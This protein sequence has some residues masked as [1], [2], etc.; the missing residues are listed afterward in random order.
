[1]RTTPVLLSLAA[2]ATAA[3]PAQEPVASQEPDTA[4]EAQGPKRMTMEESL[5]L[6]SW[7]GYR[8]SADNAR[9]VFTKR[10]M[11]PEDW[12]SVTHV[13]VHEL[14]TGEELQLTNS[15]G[16]E[17][18]PR[19][20]PDGR[21]LFTSR[22]GEGEEATNRLWVIS[23]RGGEAQPFFDDE[24]APTGGDFTRDFGMLAYTEESDRPDKE[25]WEARTKVRDDGY[26][27]EKKLTYDHLW[28]YDAETGEKTQI[29]DDDFDDNGPRWSP[30]GRWIAFT[31]NRTG[32]RMGDPDRSD[33][34]DIFV[35][36]ADG[37]EP[38][39][40]TTNSGPDGGPVWSPDGTRIAYTGSPHQNSGAGQSDVWVVDVDGG[41]PRNLTEGLDYSASGVVW[42]ADGNQIYFSVAEGLTS[43]LYRIPSGGGAPV[44]VLPDDEFVYGGA[45]LSEDGSTLLFTGSSPLAP[46]EVFLADADGSRVRRVL[47]P[48]NGMAGF[49]LARV[50]ALT[51][52]GA[53]GWE[54][55]GVLTYPLGYEPGSRVP[56]VLSVHGGPHGRFS[57]SFNSGAQIWAARGYAVLQGNPRGS[58][59]RTWE[60]SNANV[61]DWGGKDFQDLMAGVDHVIGMGVADPDRLVV[62]GGSYGG[63]MTFWTVTQTDR[64]K[65]AIGHAAISDWYSFYGQTDIPHLLEF[66]FGGLPWVT[67]ETFERFSPI[68]YAENV[69]T[70]LL[71]THGEEDRRVPIS[72]GEQ[73]Y[74]SLKK[75]G[76][77]VEFL[78]FPRE[79]H[80]IGE[81]RH[82]IFLDAEQ[83]A[84]IE[85]F[86]FP[87]GRPVTE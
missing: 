67:K 64:F 60:F 10:E 18:N 25:E 22:R 41:S 43:R 3:A 45:Q 69:A 72:Q 15:P 7:G 16:G 87:E 85:R 42:S 55:E 58:S 37:G 50:E 14:D 49:E 23:L 8:L 51:W 32:T 63:F 86:L 33:N 13:W 80:G 21:V 62:M 48:T 39:R 68:E 59:G 2:I 46:G 57:R 53:D 9:I 76:K 81:P 29:T 75:M 74:R 4:Q 77:T 78:R 35:V 84:W 54:I 30:D 12:E 17:S 52:E 5:L 36:S 66:G 56:M 82:R 26:Y 71:I 38:R 24:E 44:S 70:P 11:D 73:Y 1:M 40:L 65:A 6:P 31:S 83:A 19:W 20:L 61:M 47:S 79:G 34:S 27:A 28:V